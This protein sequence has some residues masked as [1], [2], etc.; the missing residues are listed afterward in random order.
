VDR[1]AVPVASPD[2]RTSIIVRWGTGRE[3]VDVLYRRG[4]PESLQA[5]AGN[6]QGARLRQRGQV[7][8]STPYL[9]LEI[10]VLVDPN[11]SRYWVDLDTLPEMA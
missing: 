6:P 9:D 4:E 8:R 1:S 2:V 3:H 7:V 11:V 5:T 10:R